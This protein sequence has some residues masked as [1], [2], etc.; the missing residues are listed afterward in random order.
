[1]VMGETMDQEHET[2]GAGMVSVEHP[3]LLMATA[4]GVAVGLGSATLYAA[5]SAAMSTE[6]LYLIILVGGVIGFAVVKV[7]GRDNWV[8]GLI[9]AAI[10]VVSV[11]MAIVLV[12][13]AA[14]YGGLSGAFSHL[15]DLNASFEV[16]FSDPLGYVWSF[17][18]VAAAFAVGSGRWQGAQASAKK[19]AEAKAIDDA[20][21]RE[22]NPPKA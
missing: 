11:A 7:S 18:A 2:T 5:I 12:V 14:T 4:V 10:A 22:N 21:E 6:I 13:G 19:K 3:Q 16:Y 8:T 20:M 9:S 1:M 15:G 17:A